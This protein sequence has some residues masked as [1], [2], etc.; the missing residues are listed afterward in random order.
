[1]RLIT[2]PLA[3]FLL[4]ANCSAQ[5]S[6]GG[7][8][9]DFGI[10]R[11]KA[12]T[13]EVI[14]LN[15]ATYTSGNKISLQFKLNNFDESKGIS[16]YMQNPCS[17]PETATKVSPGVYKVDININPS[18]IDGQCQ[19][20]LRGLAQNESATIS[21]PYKENRVDIAKI[22]AALHAFIGHKTWVATTSTGTNYTL[23]QSMLQDD[24]TVDHPLV[25]MLRDPKIPVASML[26]V[27]LP[28]KVHMTHM[29]CMMEGTFSGSTA[30]L[31]RS[32]VVPASSCPDGDVTLQGK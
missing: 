25:A 1:M 27:E 23:Q 28:N 26:A 30:T 29:G 7:K 12:T 5:L 4:V 10:K 20:T 11:K 32:P 18:D 24:G 19:I 2:F 6:L 21:L 17:A 31:K 22:A 15:P 3:L 16:V 13:A 14:L 8:K 9:I